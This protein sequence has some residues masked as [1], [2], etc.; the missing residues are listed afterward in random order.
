MR[1][2]VTVIDSDVRESV[3]NARVTDGEDA[4]MVSPATML[5]VVADRVNESACVRACDGTTDKRPKP[6]A[7]T[8]TLDNVY[9][10]HSSS[11][12]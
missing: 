7:A 12:C 9:T 10:V 6:I 1:Y 4:V 3:R 5:A 2:A 11:T 8:A